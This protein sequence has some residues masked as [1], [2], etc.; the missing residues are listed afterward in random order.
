MATHS[1]ISCLGNPW[2]GQAGGAIVHGIA[3][4][5]GIA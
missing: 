4:E 5:S 3:K 2:A 1:S